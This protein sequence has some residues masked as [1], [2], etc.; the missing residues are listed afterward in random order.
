MHLHAGAGVYNTAPSGNMT[1]IRVSTVDVG[2]KMTQVFRAFLEMTSRAADPTAQWMSPNRKVQKFD[3]I[4]DFGETDQEAL[5]AKVS[6]WSK[7]RW[8]SRTIP[9][10][11]S[12]LN[13]GTTIST[14]VPKTTS[15]GTAFTLAKT[16]LRQR[17]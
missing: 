13:L 14:E 12:A 10:L 11:G 9:M 3:V 6:D 16:F 8:V 5:L 1:I 15:G 2:I 17:Q 4:G 7:T